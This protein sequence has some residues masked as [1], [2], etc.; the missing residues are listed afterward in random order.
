[1]RYL[2]N[3]TVI[4]GPG[5]YHYSLVTAPQAAA[6]LHQYGDFIS[7]IGYPA[8]A[9]HIQEIAGIQPAISREATA[10][11]PGDEALVV[12]LKYR[13]QN[14]GEKAAHQPSPEDWE[15]GILRVE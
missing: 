6:W 14:P 10:M 8:T 7:R 3:S 4:T 2:L 5:R 1:M 12:R 9:E 11:Q 13:V 15:Y